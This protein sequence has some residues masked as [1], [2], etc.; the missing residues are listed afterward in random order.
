MFGLICCDVTVGDKLYKIIFFQN[1]QNVKTMNLFM[2]FVF[3][4]H[5]NTLFSV[6]FKSQLGICN[7]CQRREIETTVD[8]VLLTSCRYSCD[9]V[10]KQNVITIAHLQVIH[11]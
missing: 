3:I 4:F 7:I 6:L 11:Y 2:Y 1:Y 5:I 8:S 10:L 9:N